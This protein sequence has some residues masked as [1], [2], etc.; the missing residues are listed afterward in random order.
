MYPPKLQ[1]LLLYFPIFM[2]FMTI[3]RLP[4]AAM[5]EEMHEGAEQKY[6]VRQRPQNVSLVLGPQEE[7]ADNDQQCQYHPLSGE[8][9][10]SPAIIFFCHV[11]PPS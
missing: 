2:I 7:T 10:L 5:H 6:Q 11:A 8:Y 9:V 1:T 3:V 4:M